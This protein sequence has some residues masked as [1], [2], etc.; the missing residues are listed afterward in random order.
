[1]TSA[2]SYFRDFASWEPAARNKL[3]HALEGFAKYVV[4]QF[5]LPL[6]ASSIKTRNQRLRRYRLPYVD[7]R[8]AFATTAVNARPNAQGISQIGFDYP[9]LLQ[10]SHVLRAA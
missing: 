5:F 1:M 8:S 10:N 3:M 2:L 4:T 6:R 7:T 9:A